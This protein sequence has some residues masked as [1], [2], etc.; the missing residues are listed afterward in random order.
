MSLNYS[1]IGL[2]LILLFCIAV[3]YIHLHYFYVILFIIT[4][5]GIDNNL[6]VSYF[7]FKENVLSTV[8]MV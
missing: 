8:L 4:W 5:V 7:L 6:I 3:Y 1:I 2:I